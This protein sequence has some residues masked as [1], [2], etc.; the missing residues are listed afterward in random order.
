MI[1]YLQVYRSLQYQ[2]TVGHGSFL[3][4]EFQI[5]VFQNSHI[6]LPVLPATLALFVAHLFNSRYASSTVNTYVSAPG[7]FHRL[8]GLR[9]PT[10]T[11]YITEMLNP[12]SPNSD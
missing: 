12:L 10:K 1:F 5:S 2:R 11:F 4:E 9:D 6:S 8:A 7:Y 3:C